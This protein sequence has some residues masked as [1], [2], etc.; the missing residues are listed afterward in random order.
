VTAFLL[1]NLIGGDDNEV[2]NAFSKAGRILIYG[3]QA[4]AL[5]AIADLLRK[6]FS[7][8]QIL[9]L[10]SGA[11]LSTVDPNAFDLV[12]VTATAVTKRSEMDK[13]GATLS[14]AKV[15]PVLAVLGDI[16]FAIKPSQAKLLNLC[17][18]FPDD[19]P[20]PTVLAGLRFLLAG[21]QYMPK[22]TAAQP[23]PS[24]NGAQAGLSEFF[25]QNANSGHSAENVALSTLTAREIA[26]LY[27]L[28]K[29]LPNKAIARELGI[30]ENTTKIHVRGVLRKLGCNNRTEAAMMAQ[31]LIASD[32]N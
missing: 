20:P 16:G 25:S 13:L 12:I 21:G 2:G 28:S 17:G 18:V 6:E 31:K 19:T 22:D 24:R 7:G 3:G 15:P 10:R 5:V 14:K 32:A 30:A 4:F 27:A 9:T 26:V 8:R 23:R 29:G 11:A 1:T